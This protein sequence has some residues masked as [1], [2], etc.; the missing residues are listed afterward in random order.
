MEYKACAYILVKQR[1]P[2]VI[3]V[4]NYS[5]VLLKFFIFL[6]PIQIT[7]YLHDRVIYLS[8]EPSLLPYWSTNDYQVLPIN[9][10]SLGIIV[11]IFINNLKT[12]SKLFSTLTI[13]SLLLACGLLRQGHRLRQHIFQ[14]YKSSYTYYNHWIQNTKPYLNHA[15]QRP[16]FE[17]N[18]PIRGRHLLW[19]ILYT[20]SAHFSTILVLHKT[21]YTDL[22]QTC[23]PRPINLAQLTT[24]QVWVILPESTSLYFVWPCINYFFLSLCLLCKI[25]SIFHLPCLKLLVYLS[26]S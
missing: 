13:L 6:L 26:L 4:H 24:S 8:I 1:S 20:T 2:T 7:S 23:R 12:C 17:M 21:K 14:K 11:Q 25:Y 16:P 19:H 3:I 15:N 22:G 18:Q 10:K 9:K 5:Y